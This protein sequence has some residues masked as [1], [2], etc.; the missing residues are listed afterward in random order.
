MKVLLMS[1]LRVPA[2]LLLV[3]L[4]LVSVLKA[5][6]TASVNQ[7][8]I[9]ALKAGKTD[10]AHAA[11]WGFDQE[12]A[13][14]ALQAAINSGAKKVIVEKMSSPWIVKPLNLAS[15]QEIVFQEGVVLLAKK[16]EFKPRTASL[17]NASLKQNIRLT[18]P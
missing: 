7:A 18:G 8:A 12:D 15:N 17:L 9:D 10:V 6:P 3:C 16:G 11:W 5:E 13:T 4:T 1:L 2:L 14:A